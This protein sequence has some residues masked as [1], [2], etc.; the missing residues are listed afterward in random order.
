MS[1]KRRIIEIIIKISKNIEWYV[2][3][4]YSIKIIKIRTKNKKRYTT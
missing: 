4:Y 3:Y 1:I 2:K